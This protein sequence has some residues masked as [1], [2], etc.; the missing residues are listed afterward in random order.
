MR[1]ELWCLYILKVFQERENE[2][3]QRFLK[4]VLS[5]LAGEEMD[6]V[7]FKNIINKLLE[8]GFI[9]RER[10]KVSLTPTGNSIITSLRN[11][12]S[13]VEREFID[14]IVKEYVS[15][16]KNKRES[17]LEGLKES[18]KGSKFTLGKRI[19][20][21]PEEELRNL[22][23][24]AVILS[25]DRIQEKFYSATFKCSLL[26]S[27]SKREDKF[28]IASKVKHQLKRDHIVE[29]CIVIPKDEFLTIISPQ[30]IATTSITVDDATLEM[31]ERNEVPPE[32]YIYQFLN[33][34]LIPEILRRKGFT[35]ISNNRY[36]DYNNPKNEH[37]KAGILKIYPGFR[38][39]VDKLSDK[40]Y[41]L[42]ID[43]FFRSIFSLNDFIRYMKSSGKT[44]NEIK[45]YIKTEVRIVRTLPHDSLGVVSE[46]WIE[47]KDMKAEKIN[48]TNKSFY[49]FWKE[50]HNVLL[51]DRQ[52]LIEIKFND[53][54]FKYPAQVVYIDKRVMEEKFYYVLK[55]M[56]TTALDP[57]ERYSKTLEIIDTISG[58]VNK[59]YISF[60]IDSAPFPL[61][62]LVRIGYFRDVYYL[63]PPLLR[64]NKKRQKEEQVTDPRAVFKFGPYSQEK[65]ITIHSVVYP[66]HIPRDEIDGFIEELC[67]AFQRHKFGKLIFD[68]RSYF[69][70]SDDLRE[71]R[72]KN[73]VGQTPSTE[74]DK[75]SIALVILPTKLASQKFRLFFKEKFAKMRGIPTQILLE[76]TLNKIKEGG[77]GVI[78]NLMIQVYSKV[79]VE[80]EAI[81][82]LE[83]PADEKEETM[84][85]GLGF[86][87]KP[88]EGKRANS[89]AA[90][91][92]A[93][94]LQL[95]WKAI[96]VPFEG[97][98]ITQKWFEGVLRFLGEN[99]GEKTKRVVI[100]R[101]GD[102]YP[103]EI[104][105]MQSSI[106][107]SEFWH[108]FD[109]NF[110]SVKDGIRRLYLKNEDGDLE[111][112]PSGIF[113]V[114]NDKEILCYGSLRQ[115]A[116][117]RNR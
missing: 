70:I 81:W 34:E 103:N 89:F 109:I 65:E 46:I 76:D 3:T 41:L 84:Y 30:P 54:T 17:F 48:G 75:M 115:S 59:S 102:T 93:R 79:L 69:T 43:P 5:Y 95:R 8:K 1:E 13:E 51:E 97:R 85:V 35:P 64:F 94:G 40:E 105:I 114:L 92:D 71:E 63:S 104:Q 116:S 58:T 68:R 111:N 33:K 21:I 112:P 107:K 87:Q 99:I 11:E 6:V 45:D 91:C 28:R 108:N 18:L 53:S 9:S 57:P 22:I 96:G 27:L 10:D 44:D 37:T 55:E 47:D 83:K 80:G 78:K 24:N 39:R 110:V 82:V 49:E 20:K 23:T 15:L 31:V 77:Y 117:S 26:K 42:W 36:V 113:I 90:L 52:P 86:S 88:L 74:K 7:E 14:D 60:K 56:P 73:I 4:I 72:I 16:E 29:H 67:T 106:K 50:R 101:R 12:I 25:V 98:Y 2:T 100:F 32:S 66:M 62:E 61:S 38:I 19:T